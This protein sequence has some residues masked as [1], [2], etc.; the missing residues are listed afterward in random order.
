MKIIKKEQ[1]FISLTAYVQ[2]S[3]SELKFFLP[4]IYDYLESN[5]LNY[6]MIFVDDCS[7]D[8]SVS[9]IEDISKKLNIFKKI[10]IIS[11]SYYQGTELSMSAAIDLSIG[12]LVFEFE[13]LNIQYQ[14]ELIHKVYNQALK[15][16]DIVS[17]IPNNQGPI[18]TRTF[19]FIYN[20]FK[21]SNQRLYKETFRILSRRAI[22]RVTSLNSSL[23]Y[24][25]ILYKNSGLKN[26][27]I[28]YVINQ[29]H[30]INFSNQVLHKRKALAIDVILSYTDFPVALSFIFFFLL[31]TTTF[32][33]IAIKILSI[34]ELI[35]FNIRLFDI[36]YT[37]IATIVSLLCAIIIK[38]LSMIYKS[39]LT[40]NKYVIESVKKVI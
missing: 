11:M 19:Y 30:K 26:S 25:K 29:K 34:Y 13:N 40:K 5:F 14:S 35:N 8:D 27:S 33:L 15:G 21:N 1:N 4:F 18:Y 10:T 20:A 7:T 22:N 32:S 37:F 38:Y 31:S 2:N 17:A 16:Y 28:F 23:P 24:R 9:I 12:D 39:Q 3:S 36:F 6:E